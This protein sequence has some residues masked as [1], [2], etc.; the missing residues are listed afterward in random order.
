[1]TRPHDGP[2]GGRVEPVRIEQRPL[3]VVAKQDQLAV[4]HQVDA[5][6]RGRDVP[7]HVPEAIHPI[8]D[9][10]SLDVVQHG[11]EGFQVAV[12][13]ADNGLH[14]WTLPDWAGRKQTATT[15]WPG[16]CEVGIKSLY[17]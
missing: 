1:V 11:L 16:I 17:F 14:A 4:H 10:L 3:I 12:D 5:L 8:I 7:D 6:A 2:L 15:K 9:L 13:I